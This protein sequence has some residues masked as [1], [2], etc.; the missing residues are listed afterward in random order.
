M[1]LALQV[2]N[3]IRLEVD[4]A[5]PFDIAPTVATTAD[6]DVVARNGATLERARS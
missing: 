6:P 3:L 1:H 5:D 4:D 2:P